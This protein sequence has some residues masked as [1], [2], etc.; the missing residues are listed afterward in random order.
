MMDKIDEALKRI[1]LT[2]EDLDR[3]EPQSYRDFLHKVSRQP[4]RI[5]RSIFQVFHDMVSSHILPLEDD[6]K[7]DPESIHYVGYDCSPLFVADSD[8]PFFA[9]RLFANR[10]VN[11]VDALRRGAQ[12]NKIYVFEGPPGS[13][14]ST[15]LNNLLM[16]FE[17]YVNTEQG[18]MYETVW[19]LD[20]EVLGHLSDPEASK[21]LEELSRFSNS[22]SQMYQEVQKENHRSSEGLAPQGYVEVPCPSHDHPILMIPKESR[23]QVFDDLFKNDQSK[24]EL[25][26]EKEYEWVFRHTPC[27]ICSSLYQA[28]LNLVKDPREVLK[29][30]YARPYRFNRR[31]GEGISVFTPGDKPIKQT[32]LTNELLQRRINDLLR[33]SNQVRY[34]F[35]R[36]AKTNNGIYAL[37]DV[38]SHNTERMIELHNIVS[39]GVHKLEDIEEN[40]NSLFLA[41][42]NPEDKANIGNIQSF[43]DRIEYIKVPYVLDLNTEVQIYR[44]IFGKSIDEHFLPRVLHN[45]ARVII[46]TRMKQTSDALTEWIDYPSKYNLYCDAH[47]QLLKMEI[48]TGNIPKWLTEDDHR[49]LTAKRRSRIIAESEQEGDKGFSG[50]DSIRIFNLFFSTYGHRERLI[51]M[52]VLKEFFTKTHKELGKSIPPGFLD[53]LQG[54]YDY[55]VLQEVKESLYSYNEEGIVRELKNYLFAVNY[56]PGTDVVCSYTGDP[57]KIDD[58][59]F[60]RI[61][62]RLLGDEVTDEQRRQLRSD[63]QKQY[64]GTTLTQEV[65]AAGVPLEKTRLFK[66]LYQRYVYYLKDRVLDPF[67]DNENFRRAIK[68]YASESFKTYDKKIRTDVAFL[69]DNLRRRY[70][71]SQA[72]A[73]E[74]CM[75]VIDNNLA[76]TF[77]TE[78]PSAAP[79]KGT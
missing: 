59:F 42:M 51:N 41:L 35:S 26:T 79:G 24:W 22:F 20:R 58:A 38:K 8:N 19:R 17:Q 70:S 15:F 23:R 31:L 54:M 62:L 21:I 14:K 4:T 67:L 37:M 28:L 16:K 13:G 36:H 32:I 56:E 39:E 76:R 29:M 55:T 34:I 53:S 30:V 33:D 5:L 78:K 18:A 47:L 12:Q 75:Y 9:D 60:K 6:S 65:L 74:M 72:G 64:A 43:S 2:Q 49:R 73:K 48:Y 61:E 27:T 44:N 1:I 52:T 71:Y 40:V 25:F 7:F 45:F 11:L 77:A 63:V 57:L 46:S 69:I 50:R 10:L 66:D 3:Y 68:D